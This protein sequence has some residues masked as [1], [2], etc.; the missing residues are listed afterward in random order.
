[1]K[2]VEKQVGRERE[3]ACPIEQIGVCASKETTKFVSL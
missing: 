1:V 2:V 3:S